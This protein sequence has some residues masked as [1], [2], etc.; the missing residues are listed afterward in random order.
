MGIRD[1]GVSCDDDIAR[2]HIKIYISGALS[3]VRKCNLLYRDEYHPMEASP[4][5]EGL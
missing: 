4:K 3:N 2:M 5:G 1:D